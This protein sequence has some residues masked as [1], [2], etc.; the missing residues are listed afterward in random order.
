M[1]GQPQA[2]VSKERQENNRLILS[3]I[4]DPCRQSFHLPGV[5]KVPCPFLV[6]PTRSLTAATTPGEDP[7]PDP[8][9]EL[10]P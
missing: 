4:S 6:V 2:P 8:D 5:K 9:P 3:S 7:D 10:D 1:F